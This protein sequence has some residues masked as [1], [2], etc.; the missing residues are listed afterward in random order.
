MDTC[1]CMGASISVAH[2]LEKA[3]VNPAKVVGVIGD[4]TFLHSGITPLLDM[5]YNGS[6]GTIL[7]LDNGTTAMTGRQEHPGTGKRLS[8]QEAPRVNLEALVT[9][10]GVPD[11][12]VI[13]P[14]ELEAMEA[15]LKQALAFPGVSVLIARRPCMLIPHE[16]YPAQHVDEET[17]KLCGRCLK[18][19]CPAISKE[20]VG[21]GGEKPRYRPVIND[22][23]CEGCSVC[24]QTCPFAVIKDKA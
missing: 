18:I 10:L 9:A 20:Q 8:G 23:L 6:H 14:Y 3:G 13:D 17:C 19:G 11:V 12:E 5:V 7:I 16:D 1:I 2:G 22:L 15:R 21:E 4:S 24:A